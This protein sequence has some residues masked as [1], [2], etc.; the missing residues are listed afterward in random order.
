MIVFSPLFFKVSLALTSTLY[1]AS[2]FVYFFRR[3]KFAIAQRSPS[4]VLLSLFI[5]S[6]IGISA[7][8]CGI[9]D[10]QTFVDNCHT[11]FYLE[12]A[13][14]DFALVVFTFRL[15][16]FFGKQVTSTKLVE[17]VCSCSSRNAVPEIQ[18]DKNESKLFKTAYES[19]LW[20]LENN[21]NSIIRVV[22]K[23]VFPLVITLLIMDMT[24]GIMTYLKHHGSDP[25]LGN[26]MEVLADFNHNKL[27]VYGVE[28]TSILALWPILLNLEDNFGIRKEFFSGFMIMIL[29][30]VTTAIQT[31]DLQELLVFQTRFVF[32]FA[33][34]ILAPSFWVMI[35]LFPTVLS[36]QQESRNLSSRKI[37]SFTQNNPSEYWTSYEELKF[38][39]NTS[40]IQKEFFVYLS[41]EFATENILFYLLCQEFRRTYEGNRKDLSVLIEKIVFI[42]ETFLLPHSNGMINISSG[43]R[44]QLLHL[45]GDNETLE[46]NIED[47]TPG[48]F[49]EAQTEIFRMLAKDSFLRFRM[50]EE[51]HQA[52]ERALNQKVPTKAESL[53]SVGRIVDDL[54]T[55]NMCKGSI[56]ENLLTATHGN[57]KEIVEPSMMI[58]SPFSNN[59]APNTDM[60]LPFEVTY[61]WK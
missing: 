7:L 2:G 31:P 9:V 18:T 21:E 14:V 28:M 24:I 44:I 38:A 11:I 50:T 23:L 39:L 29:M 48:I 34:T 55:P 26:C 52:L 6:V 27:A 13:L 45:I 61:H 1:L 60:E 32:F 17:K 15:L 41:K 51:Y 46:R 37:R 56:S 43:C 33:G 4:L 25:S 59:L 36:L 8:I 49:Q 35:A 22:F 30:S 3:K 12:T 58:N 19:F 10:L 54:Y 20:M 42:R 16:Y 53:L 47:I 5:N 57:S 40:R